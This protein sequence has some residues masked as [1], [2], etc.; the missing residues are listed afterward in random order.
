[1]NKFQA[2]EAM[3]SGCK[4]THNYFCKDEW[5]RMENGM[6]VFE[7][8]CKCSQE[9]FWMDRTAFGWDDGWSLVKN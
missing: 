3:K 6:M 8:G 7:D 5:V 9:M 4:L 1:M 2:I